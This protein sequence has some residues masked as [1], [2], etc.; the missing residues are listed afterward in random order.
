MKPTKM[1]AEKARASFGLSVPFFGTAAIISG[2]G[3]SPAAIAASSGFPPGRESATCNAVFGRFSGFFSKHRLIMFST[4]GSMVST[5]FEGFGGVCEACFLR[6][7]LIEPARIA[8]SPVKISNE[9]SER[10]DVALCRNLFTRNL[11]GRHICG[12]A[13]FGFCA[14]NVL[15]KSRD[16]KIRDPGFPL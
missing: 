9:K 2:V 4:K 7:S 15:F 16:S 5:S 3:V 1:N 6:S 11:L 8:C 14:L 12:R 13:D 10:I